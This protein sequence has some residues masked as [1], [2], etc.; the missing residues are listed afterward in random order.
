MT[1]RKDPSISEIYEAYIEIHES[2]DGATESINE[3]QTDIME[4]FS[5][6]SEAIDEIREE[7]ERCN[8]L[9][10]RISRQMKPVQAYVREQD[11]LASTLLKMDVTDNDDHEGPFTEIC[12]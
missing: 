1:F 11:A 6:F 2:F 3:L 12:Q 7:L 10:R 9:I 8:R 5:A 4:E